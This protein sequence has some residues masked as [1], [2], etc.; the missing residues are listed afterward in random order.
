MGKTTRLYLSMSLALMP[1][2][3]LGGSGCMIPGSR[4]IAD[5][6]GKVSEVPPQQA[7]NFTPLF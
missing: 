6:L 3:L 7:W 4:G 2:I 5:S 1:S